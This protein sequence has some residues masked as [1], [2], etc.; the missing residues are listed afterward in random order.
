MKK[1]AAIALLLAVAF[2]FLV[3]IGMYVLSEMPFWTGKEIHIKT[4]PVDP[5]S[6]FRGNY[7][8]LNYDL[9]TIST[10]SF[11]DHQALRHGEVV[12]VNLQETKAGLYEYSGAS[13]IEPDSGIFLKGRIQ[14]KRFNSNQQVNV[15]YGIEA[16]FAPKEKALKLEK[17]LRNNAVAILMV[18]KG[19]KAR[20]KEIIAQATDATTLIAQ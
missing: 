18:S 1:Y 5:R 8:R 13:L 12:Y 14:N 11:N 16:F 19:G 15:K 4:M 7:A 3:L 10:E 17:T 20:L 6:L 9:S 2:Q